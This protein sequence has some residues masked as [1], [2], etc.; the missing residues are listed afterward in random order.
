MLFFYKKLLFRTPGGSSGGDACLTALGGTPF[1]TGGDVGGS[2]RIPS[3]F[4][5]LV[6]LKPTQ[7][8]NYT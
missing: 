8:V 7:G 6:T 5:G 3:A 4:C 1:G 2:L